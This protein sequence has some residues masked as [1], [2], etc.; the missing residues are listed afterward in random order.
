LR[1]LLFNTRLA[2]QVE[3]CALFATSA[4]VTF[5][6]VPSTSQQLPARQDKRLTRSIKLA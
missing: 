2:V 3:T 6:D 1:Y 5:M 4:S